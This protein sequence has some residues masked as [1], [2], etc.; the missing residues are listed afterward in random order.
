MAMFIPENPRT[1]GEIKIQTPKINL[2]QEKY[3]IIYDYS[4]NAL[5]ITALK[6]ENG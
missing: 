1:H 5:S 3:L 2:A 6:L 4:P